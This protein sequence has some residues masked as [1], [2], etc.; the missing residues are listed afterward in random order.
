VNG[1]FSWVLEISG[2]QLCTW[3]PQRIGQAASASRCVEF[4]PEGQARH[5]AQ[6]I[7]FATPSIL[8]LQTPPT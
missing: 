5:A 2:E 6:K 1:V 8:A 3:R 4:C 7:C